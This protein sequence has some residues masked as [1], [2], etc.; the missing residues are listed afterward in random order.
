MASP[1]SGVTDKVKPIAASQIVVEK[2]EIVRHGKKCF[3]P[4]FVR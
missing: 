3:Q 1:F 4:G 2:I